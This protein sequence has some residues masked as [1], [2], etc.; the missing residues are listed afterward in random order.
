MTFGDDRIPL[1]YHFPEVIITGRSAVVRQWGNKF[2]GMSMVFNFT[3]N[4]NE[5]TLAL[6]NMKWNIRTFVGIRLGK[7]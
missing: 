6:H 4:G 5:K 1:R 7:K 3:N 2:I